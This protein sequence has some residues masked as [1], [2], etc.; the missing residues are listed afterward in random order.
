M[1]T[2][3]FDAIADDFDRFRALPDGVP[4]TIRDTIWAALDCASAGRLLDLGAGTGRI[5][6]AFVA[7]GDRYIGVDASARMLA[8]FA[9]RPAMQGGA[10]PALVQAERPI[11]A[12]P[13][14]HLRRGADGAGHQRLPRL[15]SSP[16]GVAA[17]PPSRRVP[18]A[19]EG[20]RTAGGRGRAHADA[21][22]TDPGRG[23]GRD[24]APRGATRGCAGLAGSPSATHRRSGRRPLG[25]DPVTP[26][27]P[28]PS[29]PRCAIC[30]LAATDPARGPPA[31]DR[32]GRHHLRHAGYHTQRDPCVRA[33]CLPLL[34]FGSRILCRIPID[35]NIR[36]NQPEGS[37]IRPGIARLTEVG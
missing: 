33:R 3:D 31:A 18:R 17:N 26:G 34:A 12:I 5:G 16:V 36:H 6:E 32:L 11:T 19:G 25:V 9:R 7:A 30:R 28:G 29:R 37:V 4:R 2:S 21:T 27:L 23:R 10:T 14:G 13:R 20:G 24:R 1:G 15:A 8:C 22:L 35:M